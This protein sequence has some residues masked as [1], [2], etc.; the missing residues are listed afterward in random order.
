[1]Y[2]DVS[3][4]TY[5]DAAAFQN[6]KNHNAPEVREHKVFSDMVNYGNRKEVYS[7]KDHQTVVAYFNK[8]MS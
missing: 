2:R 1:M 3:L 7:D 8:N 6:I 5:R 4:I